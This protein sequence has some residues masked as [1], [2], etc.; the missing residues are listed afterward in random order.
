VQIGW[1]RMVVEVLAG[2]LRQFDGLVR[3]ETW[4]LSTWPYSRMQSSEVNFRM[5]RTTQRP[6]DG[7][8]GSG[9]PKDRPVSR[10]SARMH[11]NRIELSATQPQVRT[12][13]LVVGLTALTMFAFAANSLLTRMALLSTP[14]DA[15]SFTAIRL[16]AGALTLAV[17]IGLRGRVPDCSA[18]GLLSAVLLFTYAAAFSFAYR[19]ME[20]GAGAL[21]LFATAQL[22]MIGYGYARG[23]QTN[24]L[25]V[26]MALG[27]LVLFLVPA[28]T[29]PPLGATLLMIIAGLAWGAFSLLG[30]RGDSPVVG[31]A[32]SFIGSVPLAL[33]LLWLHRNDLHFDR[34]GIV[35][36]LLAG[37]VTSA[38]GYVVWYWVRVRMAAISAGTVQLSV[39][40][41]SAVLGVLLLDETV[42]PMGVT[43]ALVVLA[44]VALTTLSAQRRA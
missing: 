39:P 12:T 21:V 33:A 2:Q 36:A 29:A 38:L 23:E 13:W 32:S 14:I 26:V 40:V 19:S 8:R 16:I 34:I 41:L 44:G 4:C 1:L 11:K 10:W 3:E 17:I 20:T 37:S 24:L 25:G 42:T 27:G 6:H 43:A 31:T 7:T 5:V 15:A 18:T 35:Y 28:Q 30:R 22:L 9:P